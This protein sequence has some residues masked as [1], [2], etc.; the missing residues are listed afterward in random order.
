VGCG[1]GDVS[2]ELARIAGPQGRVVGVDLDAAKLELA[3]AEA[4]EQGLDQL[5]FREGDAC[6]ALGR[7]EFDVVYSRFVLTHLSDP[8]RC[9]ERML[10]AVRPGGLLIVEDIDFSGYFSYPQHAALLRYVH[11]Y[12]AAVRARGGDPEIGLRLPLLFSDAGLESIGIHVVQVAGL[13][14][15]VKLMPALTLEGMTEAILADGLATPAE[16]EKLV[17]ELYELARDP[18]IFVSNSRLMQIWGH[19]ARA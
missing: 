7:A 12:G 2:R 14:G 11:L 5:E 17:S 16:L 9:L 1:G 19:R 10:E 13:Q 4:R 6:G 15:D 18:R 8:R 3:R